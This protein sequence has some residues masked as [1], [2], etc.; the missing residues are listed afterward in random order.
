MGLEYCFHDPS[1]FAMLFENSV[2]VWT[3][4]QSVEEEH[5]SFSFEMEARQE[6]KSGSKCAVMKWLSTDNQLMVSDQAGHIHLFDAAGALLFRTTEKLNFRVRA[7]A[8]WD[9]GFFLAGD[10]S[11]IVQFKLIDSAT[12]LLEQV[13][14]L[15]I[16][17]IGEFR[18][19]FDILALQLAPIAEDRLVLALSNCQL[20]VMKL[21]TDILE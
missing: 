9:K 5:I 17:P 16:K 8:L 3:I 10:R 6:L 1:R 11:Q 12:S 19:Q 4:K 7:A 2:E 18:E 14:R 20:F 13:R 21:E 15:E